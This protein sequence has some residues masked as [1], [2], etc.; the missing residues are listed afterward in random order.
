MARWKWATAPGDR[1]YA[2]IVRERTDRMVMVP[3]DKRAGPRV[4]RALA[5]GS[6]PDPGNPSLPVPVGRARTRPVHPL[7]VL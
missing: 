5:E 2:V 4:L 3:L 7:S 1:V 6:I